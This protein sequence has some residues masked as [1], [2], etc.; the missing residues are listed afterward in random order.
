MSVRLPNGDERRTFDDYLA[1][2]TKSIVES[3]APVVQAHADSC[4]DRNLKPIRDDLATLLAVYNKQL[5]RLAL[6]AAA[7]KIITCLG[8]PAAIVFGILAL[9]H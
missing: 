3:T 4:Y 1:E 9:V 7:G 2:I 8:V 6:W 5:G